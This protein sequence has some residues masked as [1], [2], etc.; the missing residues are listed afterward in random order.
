[1]FSFLIIKELK[2][3]EILDNAHHVGNV[4]DMKILKIL[5]MREKLQTIMNII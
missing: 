3:L 4:L 1:M 5:L 2:K